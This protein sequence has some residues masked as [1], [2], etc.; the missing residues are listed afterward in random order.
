MYTISG[1]K[2]PWIALVN[3]HGI[4]EITEAQTIDLS[5]QQDLSEWWQG[6]EDL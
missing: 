5:Q 2:R 3:G 6:T 1:H 4:S